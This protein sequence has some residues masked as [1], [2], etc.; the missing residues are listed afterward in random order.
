VDR[1]LNNL[2]AQARTAHDLYMKALRTLDSA[3]IRNAASHYH[4]RFDQIKVQTKW[5][6][7]KLF[8]VINE[9]ENY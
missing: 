8:A 7:T 6:L 2:I 4:N 1:E 3:T 5:S 9:G